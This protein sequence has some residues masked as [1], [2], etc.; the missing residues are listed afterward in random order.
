MNLLEFSRR[1]L[2]KKT[3]ALVLT[4][5]PLAVVAAGAIPA[6]AGVV[7]SFG[8][9]ALH[10]LADTTSGGC[11]G[12]T[13]GTQPNGSNGLHLTGDA[14]GFS[15]LSSLG[16]MDLV[17]DWTGTATGTPGDALPLS[18]NFTPTVGT[19]SVTDVNSQ[20]DSTGL[21]FALTFR[22]NG[23]LTNSASNSRLTSGVPVTGSDSVTLNSAV[24]SW[25][26]ILAVTDTVATSNTTL[27]IQVPDSSV[28][29][30]NSVPEPASVLL[31]APGLAYLVLRR[32]RKQ[33]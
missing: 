24:T 26:V 11:S 8:N 6:Q 15:T 13:V 4:A 16:V 28:D 30:N 3:R 32:R 10:T 29:I 5:A 14:T 31:I 7:F 9:C 21:T 12:S 22:F 18:W 33:A 23:S 1:F 27:R 20:T 25:E 19:T 17:M 2:L